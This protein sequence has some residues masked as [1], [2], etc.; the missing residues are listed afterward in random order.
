MNENQLKHG[1]IPLHPFHRFV[2]RKLFRQKLVKSSIPFNWQQGYDVRD[3]T[4]QIAIKN[5]GDSYSCGGQAGS[6]FIEIQRRLQKINEGSISAKSVYAPIAY[7]GGGTTV[8]ALE[9][10]IAARGAE[11]EIT[12]SSYDAKGLPLT[13]TQYEDREWDT[14]AEV[15]PMQ[16]RAGYTPVDIPLNIDS[17]ASTIQQYGAVIVEVRGQNNGTWLTAYPKPPEPTNPNEIWQH[18]MILIG[19]KLINGVETLIALNSWGTSVGEQGV[20][21]FLSDYV[22]YG[23]V[24]CFSFVKDTQIQPVVGNN[25]IWSWLW[26]YFTGNPIPLTSP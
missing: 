6:Y 9:T 15:M 23:F 17:I 24:D 11:L 21:Y 2:H 7:P 5:Q 22:D 10:Q 12:V 25:S 14:S 16:S 8:P 20:Q 13:E 26:Y 1:A 18:F 4:G 19:A 3:T